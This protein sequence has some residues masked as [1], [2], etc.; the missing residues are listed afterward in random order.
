MR[1]E[2]GVTIMQMQNM[3]SKLYALQKKL[4]CVLHF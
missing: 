4:N 2:G 1:G 3:Q